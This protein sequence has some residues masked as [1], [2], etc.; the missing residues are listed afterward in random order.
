MP[1]KKDRRTVVTNGSEE[2]RREAEKPFKKYYT[3]DK[4]D[5]TLREYRDRLKS[6]FSKTFDE[7]VELAKSMINGSM[8]KSL[9]LDGSYRKRKISAFVDTAAMFAEKFEDKYPNICIEEE[10]DEYCGALVALPPDYM[11]EEEHITLSAALFILDSVKKSGN[12][13]YASFFI[14]CN[15]ETEKE[16]LPFEFRDSVFTNDVI[17]GV[18]YLIRN[19]HGSDETYFSREAAAVT[20]ESKLFCEYR[21][22]GHENL[23][24]EK[25]EILRDGIHVEKYTAKYIRYHEKAEKMTLQEK[26]Y[27][28][29][30]FIRPEIIERAVQRYRDKSCELMDIIFRIA[31][32]SRAKRVEIA[33]KTKGVIDDLVKANSDIVEHNK[34]IDVQI[35]QLKGHRKA[36][37]VLNN[38]VTGLDDTEMLE[39]M[40]AISDMK[41]VMERFEIL[42]DKLDL[43][44]DELIR[45]M[46]YLQSRFDTVRQGMSIRLDSSDEEAVRN[47]RISN[48]YE[49]FFGFLYLIDSGDS[50]AWMPR[51]VECICGCAVQLLPWAT[52]NGQ[53]FSDM[54]SEK[55]INEES[56]RPDDYEWYNEYVDDDADQY[57]DVYSL[58]YNDAFLY[59]D[60]NLKIPKDELVPYNLAQIIYEDSSVVPPRYDAERNI[61][62]QGFV[63]SGFSRKQA[64]LMQHYKLFAEVH[65]DRFGFEIAEMARR[66]IG[67]LLSD[68]SEVQSGEDLKK[69]VSEKN[70][71]IEDLKKEVYFAVKKVAELENKIYGMKEQ[72]ES[73]NQELLELREL[74]YKIQNSSGEEESVQESSISFPYRTRARVVVYGGHATWLKVI[75]KLLPNVKFIDP[76]ADPDVNTIRNADVVWMQTNAMQHNKYNKIMEIVRI[77]KIPVKYFAYASAEKCAVQV[78]E[79]DA[80]FNAE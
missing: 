8:Y 56:E 45:E 46:A 27:A 57:D 44:T 54:L 75:V 59:V 26:Y 52:K 2:L 72:A 51:I 58:K 39:S 21:K 49:I 24:H 50:L 36:L 31:S 18:I 67:D 40:A 10:Y 23:E 1:R 35:K 28:L 64:E 53:V 6:R 34:R 77:K 78:V 29:V 4:Y 22:Y 69:V 7:G 20:P 79:Y 48:P 73:D 3:L 11:D 42:K 38:P 68:K 74:I 66:E 62:V 5:R 47:F 71:E 25:S 32:E 61:P 41:A 12:F 19:R 65:N 76:Y 30:S 17:K 43:H 16:K 60:E 80:D 63:K 9:K 14:P 33:E 15:E 70:K 37:S 55:M 13:Y